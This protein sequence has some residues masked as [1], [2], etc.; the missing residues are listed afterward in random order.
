MLSDLDDLCMYVSI[1]MNG[2]VGDHDLLG[3]VNSRV[4]E[5]QYS[6]NTP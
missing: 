4:S 6:L 3:T 2:L 1:R 5:L